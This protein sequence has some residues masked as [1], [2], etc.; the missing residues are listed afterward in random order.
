MNID[1]MTIG[2][3][4]ELAGMF[5]RNKAV[6]EDDPGPWVIGRAYLIRTVTQ[7]LIG[8]L[9]DVY[10]QELVLSDA[11]WVADTGRFAEALSTG[12]LSEVE[13]YPDGQVIIGRGSITDAGEWAHDKPR[14]VIA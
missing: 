7:Y 1:D 14:K 3:A 5:G 4:K 6:L 2:Q 11:S 8:V 12:S 9:E 13:P 10:P